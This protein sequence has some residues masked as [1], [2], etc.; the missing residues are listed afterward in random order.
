[1]NTSKLSKKVPHNDNRKTLIAIH[2]DKIK[3]FEKESN[4][5]PELQK[6]YDQLSKR[7]KSLR[8]YNTNEAH[9]LKKEMAN[10][11][12]DIE[13]ISNKTNEIDYYLK[14][15]NY[16]KEYK[17]ESSNKGQISENYIQD[18][19]SENYFLTNNCMYTSE[20]YCFDCQKEKIINHKEAI[21]TCTECGAVEDYQDNDVCNEFSEEIEVLSPFSYKRK[22][23]FKEW[24][25]MVLA[26]ESSGPS[27]EV[28]TIILEELKKDRIS[29]RD[30]VTSKLIK[31]YL[32]KNNLNRLYEHVNSIRHRVCGTKP[33][34]ISRELENKLI[35]MFE[36]IQAPFNK[37][38]PPKRNNFLSYS[39]VLYKECELLGQTQLL[40]NFQLLKA[41]EKLLD[42]DTLWS[43]IC[44]DLG[45]KYIPSI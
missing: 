36:E 26:R 34:N 1:M 3:E 25:S 21:A 39:Y 7:Y 8:N 35:S 19:L 40:E 11:Q 31:E 41:R 16:I 9:A 42:H 6:E 20:L 37:H 15:A 5:L 38:K 24:L 13:T 43:A 10:L 27:E 22:N 4:S 44:K 30:Q 17:Q 28:I 29:R 32:K 12:K 2:E 23:H 45:W 18:C 33:P 14:S